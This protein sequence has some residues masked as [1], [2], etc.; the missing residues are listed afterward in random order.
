M[1]MPRRMPRLD[2]AVEEATYNIVAVRVFPLRPIWW[3]LYRPDIPPA[4]A[5]LADYL[6]GEL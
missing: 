2:A 3:R 1:K 5:R 6:N 4:F